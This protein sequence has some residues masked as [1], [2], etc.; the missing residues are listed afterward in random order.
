MTVLLVAAGLT[1]MVSCVCSLFESILYSTR[2]GALEAE[3]A[4]GSHSRLAERFMAMKSNIAEPTSAILVLN[5]IANTAG[6]TLC[7]MY[8]TQVLGSS[9]VPVVSAVLTVAILFIG[10]ILPKTYGAT[11]WRTIWHFIVWPLAVMQ[12]GLSPI[13]KVTQGFANFFTGS[14]S[15]PP[16]TEDEIQASIRLGRKA[17][18]LSRNEIQLLDAV[19]HFDEMSVRQI[20]V[21]RRDVVFLDASWPL[22]KCLE[23]A[24]E[25]RHTRFPLCRG[26]LDDAF[27]LIHI[28]DLLGVT[29]EADFRVE[30]FARPLQHVPETLAISRL[31]RDMQRTHRHMALVDDEY[32]AVAG[33]VTMENLVEQ[34]V[35]AVQDEFDA[36][37][38]DILAEGRWTYK[39]KGQLPLAR[40]NRE[41]GLDL[42]SAEVET[43]SGLMASRLGRLLQQ[44]DRVQ[45][46]GATAEVVEE[47][48]GRADVVR[49]HMARD[50]DA[51]E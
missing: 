25:T 51:E 43:L 41:C 39:V 16:I 47:R 42:Y 36:E 21:P 14:Y 29:E 3:K 32:G 49:I 17:G 28:K 5:T 2:V 44:G 30:S 18:E 27:G 31:L 1:V 24:K 38:P 7:G 50:Q 11:H 33:M 34:I 40:V 8:A 26:S 45:L 23:V 48:N 12:K 37:A 35:G 4:E 9:M 10:E 15:T 19:F 6:A 22:K 46:R 20:M 13:I